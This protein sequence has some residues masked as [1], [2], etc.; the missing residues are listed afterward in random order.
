M[1]LGHEIDL[2]IGAEISEHVDLHL[3][4]AVVLPGDYQQTEVNRIAGDMLGGDAMAWVINGGTQV[5]F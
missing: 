3:S 1:N 4:G 5:R 2:D